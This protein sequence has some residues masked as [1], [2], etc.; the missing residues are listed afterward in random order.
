MSTIVILGLQIKKFIQIGGTKLLLLIGIHKAKGNT[1]M[2]LL[3]E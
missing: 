2:K 1:E 3:K